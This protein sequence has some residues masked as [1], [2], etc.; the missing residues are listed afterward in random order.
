MN[1]LRNKIIIAICLI[2]A[3]LEAITQDWLWV[4]ADIIIAA[5]NAKLVYDDVKSE[6]SMDEKVST[7]HQA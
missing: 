3:V 5:L 1:Y 4:T 7:D 2:A 6:R